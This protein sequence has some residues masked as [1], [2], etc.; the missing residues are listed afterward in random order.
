MD[1]VE[2]ERASPSIGCA[3]VPKLRRA[4]APP[5]LF[6]FAGELEG[7]LA[8]RFGDGLIGGSGGEP[9]GFGLPLVTQKADQTQR[10]TLRT[11]L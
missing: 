5:K 9:F 10:L 8:D 4:G 2:V 11:Q 1:V 6:P 7:A 3:K